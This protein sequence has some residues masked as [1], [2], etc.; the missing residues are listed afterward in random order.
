MQKTTNLNKE[1]RDRDYQHNTLSRTRLQQ[2][3][4]WKKRE[5]DGTSITQRV[6]NI[7]QIKDFIT[8]AV[9]INKS[10]VQI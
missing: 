5:S 8:F 7:A 2:P 1:T 9:K 4:K 10:H 6:K 3:E